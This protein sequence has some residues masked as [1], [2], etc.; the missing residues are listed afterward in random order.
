MNAA[1]DGLKIA[2]VEAFPT[3]F[4]VKEGVTLGIGRAVKR[5]CVIVKVTSTRTN[6]F[7]RQGAG[8]A[9]ADVPAVRSTAALKNLGM[10]GSLSQIDR[11]RLY[12]GRRPRGTG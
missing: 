2:R 5:D 12:A 1:N 10:A 9:K 4:P 6:W 3:S 8:I 11:R 7:A